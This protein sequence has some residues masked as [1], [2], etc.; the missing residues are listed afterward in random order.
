[1]VKLLVLKL[2][3]L[4]LEKCV[5]LH[6]IQDLMVLEI[7]MLNLTFNSFYRGFK[8]PSKLFCSH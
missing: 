6:T 4:V 2:Y 1:M 8:S 5:Y 7:S 3:K